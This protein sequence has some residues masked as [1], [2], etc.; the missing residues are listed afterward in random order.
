M[1]LWKVEKQSVANLNIY[2]IV[3]KLYQ[4]KSS[5]RTFLKYFQFDNIESARREKN[6]RKGTLDLVVLET[7]IGN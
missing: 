4:Q 2:N 7:N 6:I 1:S 3:F 5:K